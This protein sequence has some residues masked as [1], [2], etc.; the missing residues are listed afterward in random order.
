[1]FA[2]AAMTEFV[3]FAYKAVE[4]VAVV[5]YHDEGAV[6]VLKGLLE[7]I[8]GLEVEMVGGLIEDEQVYGLQQELEDGKSRAFTAR[9]HFHPQIRNL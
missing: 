1:M 8:L 7:H 9:E 5:A 6:E 2:N 4:E 3:Y